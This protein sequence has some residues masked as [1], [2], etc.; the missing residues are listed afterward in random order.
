[1]TKHL[2]AT[3]WNLNLTQNF[4]IWTRKRNITHTAGLS[5]E[6]THFVYSLGISGESVFDR[7][8]VDGL[9]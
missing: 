3:A 5:V 4:K 9:T 2:F 7:R 8:N 1:M 6:I